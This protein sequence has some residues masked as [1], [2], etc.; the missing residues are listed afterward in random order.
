MS[1]KLIHVNP[2][3]VKKL[4]IVAAVKNIGMQKAANAAIEE[5][6]KVNRVD[7]YEEKTR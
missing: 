5:Y 2:E 7:E 6:V 4:R 1:T 3:L